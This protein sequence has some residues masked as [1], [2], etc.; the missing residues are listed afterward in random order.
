MT[1]K[2]VM[3]IIPPDTRPLDMTADQV[4]IGLVAPLGVAYIAATLENVGYEVKILDCVAEGQKLDGMQWTPYYRDQN[5]KDENIRYG[6]TDLE[7]ESHIREFKPDLVG[8]SCMFS[9]RAWDAHNVCRIVKSFN[10]NIIT[11]MGGSHPT[12]TA[13]ESIKDINVDFVVK[14][15]GEYLILDL[16]KGIDY[17][18]IRP[19][20]RYTA[21]DLDDLPL[22]ARHLL[23]MPVY[24]NSDSAHSGHKASPSTNINTSRGCPGRC[25][26][27]AI[28]TTFGDAYRV[29]SPEN[30]LAEIDHLIKTYHIKELD[31]EDDNFTANKKRAMAILQGIIDRKYNLYLNSPSGLAVSCMDEELLD[32]MKEAG[33]YSVSF[34][35]ESASPLVLK[36]LMNKKVDLEKAKRLVKYGRSIGLKVKAFFILG[37]PGE[38]KET[39]EETVDYA[40]ALGADWSLFFPAT[41]LPGTPMD[42]VVRANGWLVDPNMDLRY[43]FFKTNIKTPEFEPAYVLNLKE[44]A[45]I[46][47]NFENNINMREGKF[48]RAIED[49]ADV[50]KLY[51]NL[52]IAQ[53]YLEM[54]QKKERI[55]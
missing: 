45:N 17:I 27:C 29:R 4:R 33:Y 44:E 43:N 26:F 46:L 47:C 16:I 10:P 39:M 28:R 54:A 31:I 30:V 35:I 18:P 42:K 36:K 15:E 12:A 21:F 14:G 11:V 19:F 25:N 51:P 53:K 52:E 22:P 24:L 1:I 49:F 2:K 38:T 23:N 50:V 6:L 7:I 55:I 8:V 48:D 5:L 34:A 40:L 3:L 32:K 9:N 20:P 37:Y 13:D 41:N